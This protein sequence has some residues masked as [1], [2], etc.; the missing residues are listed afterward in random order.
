MTTVISPISA[1]QTVHVF[2][3]FGRKST[4]IVD[5]PYPEILQVIWGYLWSEKVEPGKG[6]GP[7]I[8]LLAD[9]WTSR[10]VNEPSRRYS[11]KSSCGVTE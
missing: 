10:K 6:A 11:V 7:D 1:S 8:L 4:N 3:S 9:E 2:H 5:D